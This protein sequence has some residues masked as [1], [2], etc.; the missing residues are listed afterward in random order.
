MPNP[1]HKRRKQLT[2][3]LTQ[4][5]RQEWGPAQSSSSLTVSCHQLRHKPLGQMTVEDLRILIGQ[6]IGLPY[7]MPLAL[8][9]LQNDPLAKGQHYPGD[10]LCAVLRASSAFYQKYPAYR[11]AVRE[12]AALAC[13]AVQWLEEWEQ[14]STQKVLNEALRAFDAS[15]QAI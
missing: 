8:D 2:Q 9:T 13:H 4:L 3:T 14:S 10:L 6:D 5:E 1:N 11:L 12:L 7:L 15:G